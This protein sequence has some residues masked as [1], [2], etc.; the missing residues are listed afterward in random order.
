MNITSKKGFT[1][2][3]YIMVIALTGLIFL[4]LSQ[5]VLITMRSWDISLSGAELIGNTEVAFARLTREIRQIRNATSLTTAN[6]SSIT[7]TH[8]S[9]TDITYQLVGNQ[10]RRNLYTAMENVDSL[11]FEYLDENGSVIAIPITSPAETNVR[12]IRVTMTAS[13]SSQ[14]VTV[15]STV[16]LRNVR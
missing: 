11:L 14:S 16:K 10:L 12:M 15:R 9:G 8:A 13:P 5:V 3:E 4:A 6:S 1:I 2:I 7:F